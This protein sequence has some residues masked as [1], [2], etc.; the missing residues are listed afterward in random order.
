M[1]FKLEFEVS[2]RERNDIRQRMVEENSIVV[3]NIVFTIIKGRDITWTSM[4]NG[5]R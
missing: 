5:E 2:L 4:F 1:P 3:N